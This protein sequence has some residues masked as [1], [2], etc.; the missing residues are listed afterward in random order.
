MMVQPGNRFSL[1]INLCTKKA[2]SSGTL[3]CVHHKVGLSEDFDW[4]Y[5][6]ILIIIMVKPIKVYL[7]DTSW[8]RPLTLR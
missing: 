1:D 7:C 4:N 3:Y 2:D 6:N 8:P 5:R